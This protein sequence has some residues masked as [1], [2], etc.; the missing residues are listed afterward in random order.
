MK[1][2]R[3]LGA[4][5]VVTAGLRHPKRAMLM[6]YAWQVAN[7][8]VT[9]QAANAACHAEGITIQWDHGD[10]KASQ[11]AALQLKNQFNMV[12]CASL[13][14]NHLTGHAI[15]ITISGLPFNGDVVI[16][17]KSY[18]IKPPGSSEAFRVKD[19]GAKV[20]VHWFGA[21]DEVHWSVN[22]K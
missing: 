19:V 1:A 4:S 6:H 18:P 3:K 8:A 7:G 10:T 11:K 14:S 12:H 22:G 2:L 13:D 9:P 17:G 16:D 21:A 5:V 20:G 15:D